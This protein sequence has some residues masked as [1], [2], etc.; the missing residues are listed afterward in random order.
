M[1]WSFKGQAFDPTPPTHPV[2]ITG[3][4]PGVAALKP[5]AAELKLKGAIAAFLYCYAIDH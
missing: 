4:Y 3:S 2:G 5:K 1:I